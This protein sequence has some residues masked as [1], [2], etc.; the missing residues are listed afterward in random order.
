[1]ARYSCDVNIYRRVGPDETERTT[2]IA[3]STN[4]VPGDLFELPED[5]F[6]L[7]CDAILVSGNLFNII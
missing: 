5:G 1:M 7:P 4:L 2:S 6:A 3:N